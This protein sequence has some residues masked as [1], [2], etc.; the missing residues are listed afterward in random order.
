MG[1]EGVFSPSSGKYLTEPSLAAWYRA[2]QTESPVRLQ[3][4]RVPPALATGSHKEPGMSSDYEK[5]SRNLSPRE[6][7]S[8]SRGCL[9]TH[10][11]SDIFYPLAPAYLLHPHSHTDT[12]GL[13]L[14]RKAFYR[15]A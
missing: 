3:L 12:R 1:G 10:N 11:P 7:L 2:L 14:E 15:F 13:A 9:Y 5:D 4:T 6:E 8:I